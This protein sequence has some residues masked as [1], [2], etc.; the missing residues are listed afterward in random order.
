MARKTEDT[1][2]A[3]VRR[4]YSDLLASAGVD[5]GRLSLEILYLL[6][7][8]FVREYT[9][10]FWQALREDIS[11]INSGTGGEQQGLVIAKAGDMRKRKP[12]KR[13]EDGE[14]LEPAVPGSDRGAQGGGK[15]YRNHWIIKSEE[16]LEVKR[17]VDRKLLRVIGTTRRAVRRGD[18]EGQANHGE[19]D[20][21][22]RF[23]K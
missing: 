13:G 15:R 8:E 17:R 7:E 6:P 10:L 16:A 2:E 11:G 19:R 21:S 9:E 14:F 5:S 4:R 20:S 23:R 18:A 3:E 12:R 22:G 1:I